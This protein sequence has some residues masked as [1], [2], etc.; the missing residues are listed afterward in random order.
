M[1]FRV[2]IKIY[3]HTYIHTLSLV[4]QQKCGNSRKLVILLLFSSCHCL[5]ARGIVSVVL[6]CCALEDYHVSHVPDPFAIVVVAQREE[7]G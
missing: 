4:S 5:R 2:K 6:F 1:I 7:E 3:I